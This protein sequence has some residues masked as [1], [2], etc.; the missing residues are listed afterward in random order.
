MIRGE[1]EPQR[2]RGSLIIHDIETGAAVDEKF[3]FGPPGEECYPFGGPAQIL[4]DSLTNNIISTLQFD[5]KNLIPC[6]ELIST[7][8]LE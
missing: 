8:N 4:R 3:L 2:G 1:F 6:P 7:C 5:G